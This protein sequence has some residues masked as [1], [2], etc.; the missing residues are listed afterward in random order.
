MPSINPNSPLDKFADLHTHTLHSDGTFSPEE[1][2]RRAKEAKLSVLSVTDH[3]SIAGVA[4]ALQASG[5]DLE[6]IPGVELTVVFKNRELHLLGYGIR[7]NDPSLTAFF[8]RMQTYRQDRIRKMIDRLRERGV[9]VS[10]DEVAAVAGKGSMGRPHLAEV[11]VT[12]GAVRSLDE[13]FQKYLGDNAPCFVKGATL[14]VA[15]AVELIRAAGGVSS[16]AHPNHMVDDS[17][18]PE[19]VA[20]GVQAIEAFHSDHD[21]VVTEHYRQMAKRHKVL[22]TGGSD[23]HGFRKA[24]GPQLGKV[25]LPYHPYVEQLKEAIACAGH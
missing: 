11:L 2:V 3:D 15:Q 8:A 17:W 18:I 10:F 14:T 4:A 20:A 5:G 16:L 24:G 6:I 21:A 9:E 1:L 22:V 19:L 7:V 12:R 13:A 23:C 25:T